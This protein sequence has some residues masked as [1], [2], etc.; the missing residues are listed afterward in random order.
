[1]LRAV[2]LFLALIVVLPASAATLHVARDGSG[3]FTVIQAA[4]DAA[5]S[6]D[7]VMIGPGRYDEGA[8][9]SCP[10]WTAFVRVLIRQTE[11]TIIGAG[12]GQTII[13]PTTPWDLSRGWNRGIEAGPGWNSMRVHV[14]DIGFENMGYGISGAEAP[15]A[16]TIDR[17]RFYNNAKS[18]FFYAGGDLSITDSVFDQAPRNYEFVIAIA[19]SSVIVDAS[20][21]TLADAHQWTQ[22]AVHL[23]SS[24]VASVT[25]CV[26]SGGDGALALVGAGSSTVQGCRFHNQTA[27]TPYRLGCGILISASPVNVSNCSFDMQTNA[28]R[29]ISSPSVTMTQSVIADAT[30]ASIQFDDVGALTVHDSVLARGRQYTVWQWFP[31]DGKAASS[32]TNLDMTNND[33]GTASADSIAS[34]IHTCGRVVDYVPFIGQP[35]PTESTSW[36]NLK[37]QYR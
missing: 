13:G 18:V 4:V 6:G 20:Q 17:C 10:G 14:S 28:L 24:V 16:L 5:A 30:D 22:S 26:F 32:P 23:E 36:G 1:M 25:N 3:E 35:V 9:V 37:A 34:W 29:I 19:C 7:T 15:E 21:F 31:C 33:W 2:V 8:I 11:L 12:P 27:A